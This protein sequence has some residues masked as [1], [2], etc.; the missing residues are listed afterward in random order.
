MSSKMLVFSPASRDDLVNIYQFGTLHWG[1]TKTA[2]YLLH[3]KEKIRKL[4]TPP[5]EMGVTREEL[6]PAMRSLTIKSHVVFYRLQSNQIDIV[7][8]LGGRQDP[9]LHFK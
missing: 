4:M 6:F 8:V 7:R 1:P 5:P 3:L 9:R 2:D